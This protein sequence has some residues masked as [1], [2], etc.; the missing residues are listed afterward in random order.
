MT[1]LEQYNNGVDSEFQKLVHAA[2]AEEA[3]VRIQTLDPG[4]PA[5]VNQL[6]LAKIVLS[7]NLSTVQ[8]VA[9]ALASTGFHAGTPELSIRTAIVANFALLAN[10]FDDLI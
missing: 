1:L 7:A 8:F 9:V 4:N 10:M 3:T 5:H 6:R 2:L